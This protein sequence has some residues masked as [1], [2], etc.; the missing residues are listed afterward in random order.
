MAYLKFPKSFYTSSSS[1]VYGSFNHS[2]KLTNTTISRI[3]SILAHNTDASLMFRSHSF[4]DPQVRRWFLSRFVDSGIRPSQLLPIPYA[5]TSL[6]GYKDYGRINL[7]LDT[8]PVCGTTTTLD[9]LVMGVPVLT[10][11]NQLYAGAIS[12]AL[13]EQLGFFLV[14]SPN[15]QMNFPSMALK[16]ARDYHSPSSRFKLASSVR[17]SNICDP[18]II[19]KVFSQELIKMSRIKSL[20]CS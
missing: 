2:R 19:P 1:L 15:L 11:P 18:H 10:S 4:F 5:A 20:V 3:S 9:S 12:S 6:E 14:G 17:A 13:I 8:Y 16:I 7:H